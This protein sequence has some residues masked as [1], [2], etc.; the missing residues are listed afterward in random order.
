M[1]RHLLWGKLQRAGLEGWALQAV[2]A[3]YA[4]VPMGVKTQGG[5]TRCFEVR[6]GVKQGCPLSPTLFGLY[7]DDFAEGLLG[8]VGAV[9]AALPTWESGAH[10]PPLFYAEDQAL[11]AISPEGLQRQLQYLG[12]YCATWGL[13]VNTAKTKVVVYAAATPEGVGD[14]HYGGAT[15]DRVTSFR[16]LGVE[17]HSTHAS[18]A[19]AAARALAGRQALHTLRRRM[20]QS[21]LQEP[22]LAMALFDEH[23]RPV[24]AYGVE[25][26]GPQLMTAALSGRRADACE[27]VQ[28]AFLRALLG[29]QD[30]CPT[31][32]VLAE[33]GRLP[34]AIQ[35][36]VQT[37]RF[38]RRLVGLDDSRVVKQ[39]FRDSLA[40]AAQGGNAGRG[41]R[42]WAAEVGELL[43][44]L[45]QGD[46]LLRGEM[47][48][49]V[50]ES[51]IQLHCNQ[52]RPEACGPMVQ[53][54]QEE[55]RGGAVGDSTC[56]IPASYLKA[57]PERCSRVPLDR[58]RTGG[59][60][61]PEDR[62]RILRRAR[63]ERPCPCGSPL[64]S[65]RHCLLEC[66]LTAELR[67][68][69]A[70]LFPHQQTLAEFLSGEEQRRVAQ[71]V[72][73]CLALDCWA[74]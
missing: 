61:L 11:L 67:E 25:I 53:R 47:P 62:G 31:L 37:T 19:A 29:V 42:C 73:A 15:I 3:P 14:V 55:M 68:Q 24:M 2:Q 21:G 54:Y 8:A 12:T 63:E 40:L 45:G 69:F 44:L 28:L 60:C 34:L 43:S 22:K 71:Y 51:A 50:R 65:A 35:W 18:C 32:T 33:T 36:V 38:A 39:A 41:R 64:G 46:A 9:Q 56:R 5:Y 6:M 48:G 7:L 27:R 59:S 52:Y 23:V 16:Y 74:A 13:T 30:T 57:V 20:A 4:A 10:V 1:T 66:P 58:V 72:E 17:L 49:E 26:W 70:S